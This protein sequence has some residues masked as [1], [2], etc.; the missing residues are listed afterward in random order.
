[1]ASWEGAGGQAGRQGQQEEEEEG[2]EEGQQEDQC[3]GAEEGHPVGL[4]DRVGQAVCVG[5]DEV[6]HSRALLL[7]ST[8]LHQQQTQGHSGMA[9][10]HTLHEMNW[11]FPFP[12][13]CC[14]CCCCCSI[15]GGRA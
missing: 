3:L 8:L 6:G 7:S 11:N 13:V 14:C 12:G 1:M 9:Q 15:K 10:P 4:A 5:L 2:G